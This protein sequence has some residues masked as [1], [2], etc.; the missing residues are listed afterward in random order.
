MSSFTKRLSSGSYWRVG[1]YADVIC[2]VSGCLEGVY[3]IEGLKS[4]N[5]ASKLR[6]ILSINLLEV[7]EINNGYSDME[8]YV[9]GPGVVL[10]A[11]S[12]C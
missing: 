12:W 8:M 10:P 1:R 9:P 3:G 6:C 11:N 2:F 5:G 7:S 4:R